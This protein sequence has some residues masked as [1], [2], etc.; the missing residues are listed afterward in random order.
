[1]ER[2]P[3]VT[4]PALIHPLDAL[5]DARLVHVGW[6]D[7]GSPAYEIHDDEGMWCRVT[8]RLPDA[9][10]AEGCVLVKDYSENE[11]LVAALL[12][13]GVIRTTGRTFDAGWSR[14]GVVE[15][16]ILHPEV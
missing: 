9:T 3:D 13:A 6:Y 7:N 1:M 12:A 14:D 8:V 10:P 4:L 2:K 5:V 15:A 11:G 16:V